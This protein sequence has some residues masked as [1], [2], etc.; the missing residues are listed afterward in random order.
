MNSRLVLDEGGKPISVHAVARDVTD[1]T[2]A[3]ARQKLLMRELQHRTKNMLAVIQSIVSNTLA[4]NNN[5]AGAKDAILGRLHALARAQKFVA[6]GSAGGV[7]LRELVEAELEAF[8]TRLSVE[9]PPVVIGG[10]FAQMFALVLHELATNAVKHGSLSVPAGGVLVR[11]A[12]DRRPTGPELTFSWVEKGGP[13]TEA[14]VEQ[15]FGSQLIAGALAGTPRIAFDPQGFLYEITLP[16][17]AVMKP[18]EAA[19]GGQDGSRKGS[20]GPMHED[21]VAEA[22][23]RRGD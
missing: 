20:D 3:E 12:V 11:G 6:S 22:V 23:R 18:S 9:G 2:H 16:M 4:R 19:A 17:T 21:A 10:G 1:R 5:L 7:L 8:A 13:R 15:G 14:P